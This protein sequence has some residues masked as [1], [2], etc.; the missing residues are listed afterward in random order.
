MC[1]QESLL[2]P[3]NSFWINGFKVIR[4]DITSSNQRGICTLVRENIIFS[5]S[6][7][8]AFNHIS[9]EILGIKLTVANEL[10]AI[11]N[12][13]RH[14]NQITPFIFDQLISTLLST[15]SKIIFVGDFNAH[16]PWWGCEYEDSAGKTLSRIIEGHNLVILNDRFPTILLH[17][18]AKRSVIDLVLASEGLASHSHS[19]TGLD[20]ADSDHFLIFTTIGSYPSSKKVFLYELKINKKDLILL[21]HILHDSFVNLEFN[22]SED[23]AYQQMEHHIKE[24][25]YSFFPIDSRIP[26]SCIS[27]KRPPSLPWWKR[28]NLQLMSARTTRKYLT[29]P[30]LANFIEYKRIRSSCSKVL[31]K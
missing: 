13:Y 3:H 31:K 14:P 10:L 12:I 28:V 4:K 29:F 30:S 5:V 19:Y 25:L 24:Y 6:D 18:N 8:S 27:R 16:H 1:I 11:I 23:K 26:R 22:L 17:S 2:W 20:T 9:S 15:F 7:L 21:S